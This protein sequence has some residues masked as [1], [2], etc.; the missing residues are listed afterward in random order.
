M[1]S[2]TLRGLL[3]SI[4]P[5]KNENLIVGFDGSDDA[6]VYA[7]DDNMCI[8]STTDFFTPM[9]EDAKAFGRIAAANALSDVYAM[10]GKPILALNLVSFPEE[11]DIGILGE[12]LAG[13]A[14]K[15]AE[16]GVALGGGHSIYGKDIKY[17]L[18]VTGIAERTKILRNNTPKPGHSL[19]LTKPLGV[20]IS[21]A[22]SRQGKADTT[23]HKAVVAGMERLNKYAA[24][25]LPGY[26]I[27]AC[28]D[29]TGFGLLGH[30]LEMAQNTTIRLDIDALPYFSSVMDYINSGI[31]TA[32]GNRNRKAV[33]ARCDVSPLPPAMQEILFDPQTSGGLLVCVDKEEAGSLLA[34][35]QKDD[36]SAKCIGTVLPFDGEAIRFAF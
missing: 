36:P 32:G 15:A 21:M 19:I 23:S 26:N 10:G 17:G 25:K 13:G 35:I 5:V 4:P 33:S 30:M 20:G 8:I 11:S 28:T 31:T 34:A 29:I 1:G 6:A 9:L 7:L 24:E 22:A 16:A 14:E 18:A 12:I 3:Q 2:D 27:S